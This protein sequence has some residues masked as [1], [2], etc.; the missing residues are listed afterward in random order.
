MNRLCWS[1]LDHKDGTTLFQK[2]WISPR[3][4]Q[5]RW[6]LIRLRPRDRMLS[7]IGKAW[8]ECSQWWRNRMSW[9]PVQ[10]RYLCLGRRF[11]GLP[12]Y[13]WGLDLRSLRANT[14]TIP[15]YAGES[16][17]RKAKDYFT[18]DVT[19]VARIGIASFI[20]RNL[21]TV[22]S[23]RW[24]LSCSVKQSSNP[25]PSEDVTIASY[26]ICIEKFLGQQC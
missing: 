26:K 6:S 4:C 22:D 18:E 1:M 3:G 11:T 20:S 17:C 7:I 16:I 23:P 21:P 14:A 2:L 5:R 24:W 25:N 8:K 15:I 13:Y 19:G 9:S 12:L 10:R